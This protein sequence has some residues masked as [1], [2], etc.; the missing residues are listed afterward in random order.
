MFEFDHV[1]VVCEDVEQVGA[2]LRDVIGAKELRKVETP[3]M[4][5][6]EYQLS[7]TRIFVRQKKENEVLSDGSIRRAGVDHLGFSVPDL[8]AAIKRLVEAGCVLNQGPTLLRKGLSIA[9]V[10]GPGGLLME[11]LQR[12]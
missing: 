9:F 12:S 6:W 4:R 10:S 7:D 11:I 3:E 8:D 2:F 5:N 1:H